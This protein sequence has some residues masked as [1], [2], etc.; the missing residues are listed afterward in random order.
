MAT[1]GRNEFDESARFLAQRILKIG[2][3]QPYYV[4]FGAWNF[5]LIIIVK[6]RFH[7]RCMC[8]RTCEHK[9]RY[10]TCAHASENLCHS[11]L[12]GVLNCVGCIFFFNSDSKT[13][14]LCRDLLVPTVFAATAKGYDT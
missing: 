10:E 1:P 8:F 6:D 12:A 14:R 13:L 9:E 11:L 2:G 4:F 7:L 3:R 5:N